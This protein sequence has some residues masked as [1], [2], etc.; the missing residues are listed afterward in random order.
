MRF[1]AHPNRDLLKEITDQLSLKDALS[2]L[3]TSHLLRSLY[4]DGDLL[5]HRLHHPLLIELLADKYLTLQSALKLEGL[6]SLPYSLRC[7]L[8]LTEAQRDKMPSEDYIVNLLSDF[9]IICMQ[10]KLITPEQVTRFP[11]AD[12]ALSLFT[13]N[14]FI[15]LFNR[16]ITPEA[17]VEIEQ[18]RLSFLFSDNGIEALRNNLICAAD[19]APMQSFRLFGTL[20]SND[21]LAAMKAGRITPQIAKECHTTEDLLDLIRSVGI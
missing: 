4:T 2:L 10:E 11:T 16:W 14:G 15:A 13:Y 18:K 1:F 17:L 7:N 19:V 8:F 20:L 9:G 12:H 6:L 3:S 5:K 21:G